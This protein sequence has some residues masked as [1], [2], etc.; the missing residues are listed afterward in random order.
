MV[1]RTPPLA[2]VKHHTMDFHLHDGVRSDMALTTEL[3]ERCERTEPD[4]GPDPDFTPIGA[5]D[6][7]ALTEKLL[8]ELGSEKLWLFAYGSLIWKPN[9]TFVTQRR[10]RPGP[11]L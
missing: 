3:V 4:P 2:V 10:G 7:D 8:D 6:R 5:A 11:A 9:F 1:L